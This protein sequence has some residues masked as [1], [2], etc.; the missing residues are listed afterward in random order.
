M[1]P[2][3]LMPMFWV[4]E[5][6]RLLSGVAPVLLPDFDAADFQTVVLKSY[7][8]FAPISHFPIPSRSITVRRLLIQSFL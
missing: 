2:M 5:L 8:D 7:V 6:D 4:W 3:A 1:A